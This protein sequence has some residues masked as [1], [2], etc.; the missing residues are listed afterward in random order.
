MAFTPKKPTTQPA[1]QYNIAIKSAN[2]NT[3]GYINLSNEFTKMVFAKR[4]GEVTV[5][6]V[7]G[8]NDDFEAFIKS[9][10]IEVTA[11]KPVEAMD[12]SDF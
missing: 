4:Q 1:K 11:S 5:E 6:D 7:L 9:A 3:I 8:V 10:T 12:P 2:G